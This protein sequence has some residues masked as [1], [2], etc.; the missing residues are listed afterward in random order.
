M[1]NSLEN[2]R[3]EGIGID[4]ASQMNIV[5]RLRPEDRRSKRTTFKLTKESSKNLKNWAQEDGIKIKDQFEILSNLYEVLTEME[6]GS[7]GQ[8]MID[9]LKGTEE[10]KL[11]VRKTYV[12]SEGSL[13]LIKKES[14]KRRV[15]RDIFLETLI[16]SYMALRSLK[17]KNLM[18][19]KENHPKAYEI[20]KSFSRHADQTE[21]NLQGILAANDPILE[22][23]GI[24]QVI[25]MNL[26][27]DIEEELEGGRQVQS[28]PW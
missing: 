19:S 17:S 11:S 5:S 9:F 4:N 25:L 24:V 23:F 2:N 16:R 1:E 26:L 6:T 22:R 14:R 28:E 20:I 8:V 7:P 12:V 10:L 27:S 13:D 15:S 3:L 18:E 21:G